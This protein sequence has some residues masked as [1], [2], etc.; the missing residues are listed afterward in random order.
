MVG[1]RQWPPRP[2]R[3]EL[4]GGA[5]RSGSGSAGAPWVRRRLRFHC[6][7]VC[8]DYNNAAITLCLTS[9]CEPCGLCTRGLGDSVR[10]VPDA[11]TR[12]ATVAGPKILNSG[13]RTAARFGGVCSEGRDGRAVKQASRRSRWLGGLALEKYAVAPSVSSE[14]TT[15]RA[16]DES[17]TRNSKVTVPHS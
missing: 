13:P 3:R 6:Y 11:S 10:R 16:A 4:K 2:W 14:A 1:Q 9:Q 7:A 17:A 8:A 5:A 12:P 15:A